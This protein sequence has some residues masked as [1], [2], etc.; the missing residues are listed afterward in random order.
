MKG[1]YSK[2]NMLTNVQPD[3]RLGF[4]FFL[5]L[6]VLILFI[7]YFIFQRHIQ[8]V[9]KR[10]RFSCLEEKLVALLT[11]YCVFEEKQLRIDT[12]PKLGWVITLQQQKSL[13]NALLKLGTSN[14]LAFG[15]QRALASLVSE[16]CVLE[17]DLMPNME[18]KCNTGFSNAIL[19]T[20]KPFCWSPIHPSRREFLLHSQFEYQR[21]SIL[22]KTG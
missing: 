9:S 19:E 17:K 2:Y 15:R 11:I 22:E 14:H 18:M 7:S 13:G 5:L 3:T 12:I 20:G 1:L 6:F 21:N 16:L 4:V 8:S 10:P